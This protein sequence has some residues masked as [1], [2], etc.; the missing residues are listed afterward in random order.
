MTNIRK[1]ELQTKVAK[2]EAQLARC[3]KVTYPAKI[4][5]AIEFKI[6]LYSNQLKAA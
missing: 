2:L 1:Q 3:S 6:A 5:K 4:L